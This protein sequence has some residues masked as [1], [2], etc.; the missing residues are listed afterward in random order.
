MTVDLTER[1]RIEQAAASLAAIVQASDDA[2][3]RISPTGV[4]ESWNDAAERLYGWSAQ[5]AIGQ[6]VSM[7]GAPGWTPS[8]IERALA[9]AA[10]TVDVQAMRRDGALIEVSCTLSPI[11]TGD[12]IAGAAC[13]V[14]DISE[15]KRIEQAAAR[16]AAIVESSDDAIISK[17]VE[18][19]IIS[20]NAA[21]EQMYGYSAAQAVG[22][23][24]SILAPPSREDEHAQLLARVRAGER[25]RHLETVRR[26]KD[27]SLID[28]SLTVSPVH[29]RSG[30]IVGISAIARD[31]TEHKRDERELERLAQAAEYGSDAVISTDLEGRVCHWSKGAER[32]YG[33]AAQEAIGRTVED[34]NGSVENPQPD[35]DRAHALARML[36]GERGYQLETRCRHR[37]G[38][39]LEV[40]I[41]F[42]PWQ[43]DGRMVGITTVNDITQRKRRARPRAGAV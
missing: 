41:K 26:R 20:W 17:T 27:G 6:P 43:V 5:D 30:L 35:C 15:R 29:D 39:V 4:I 40:L 42:T 36:A 24:I 7:L 21:A 10:L 2:I 11:R 13:I 34:L 9:G 23:H 3:F 37:D 22:Q 16:L 31:F 25:L 14:R 28:V 18:G 8:N 12:Q 1:K 19:V 38:S 33:F 32:L